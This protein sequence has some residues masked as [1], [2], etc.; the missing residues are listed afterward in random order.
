MQKEIGKIKKTLKREFYHIPIWL[1][2]LLAFS[3]LIRVYNLGDRSFWEDE[4]LYAISAEQIID[5][6]FRI[7]TFPGS[8]DLIVVPSLLYYYLL[9]GFQLL[10]GASEFAFRLPS[11]V[12]ATL[13]IFLVYKIGKILFADKT[14]FFATLL[15]S[16]GT[17]FLIVSREA[18]PI[19]FGMFFAILFIFF[20]LKI[21]NSKLKYYI[22]SVVSGVMAFVSHFMN[23]ALLLILP[24]MI[25]VRS[26]KNQIKKNLKFM[27]PLYLVLFVV[28][29]SIFLGM[30]L[31]L[32]HPLFSNPAYE[33]YQETNFTTIL[34]NPQPVLATINNGVDILLSSSAG[35]FAEALNELFSFYFSPSY[36][37]LPLVFFLIFFV[38]LVFRKDKGDLFVAI[39]LVSIVAFLLP[40]FAVYSYLD[41]KI[42]RS[43][44]FFIPPIFLV[45]G[46][47]ISILE[48]KRLLGILLL[49]I[50]LIV[51]LVR[52]PAILEK[53]LIS[54]YI[55]PRE[56]IIQ[57]N[58]R[59][60][61][62][63]NYM[64]LSFRDGFTFK[65][66]PEGLR[67]FKFDVIFYP[68]GLQGVVKTVKTDSIVCN[69]QE[70]PADSLQ[71]FLN[72]RVFCL[73]RH[74]VGYDDSAEWD[75]VT[76][77]I[78]SE[79]QPDDKW[80]ISFVSPYVYYSGNS[81]AAEIMDLHCN[82]KHVYCNVTRDLIEH[83]G[84]VWI[85]SDKERIHWQLNEFEKQHIQ[86]EC[87]FNEMASMFVYKC[88]NEQ[89]N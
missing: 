84:R 6:P 48:N 54:I 32:Q 43:H 22:L 69:P 34:E 88:L 74:P 37:Y 20:Y 68:E 5:N 11:V 15:M 30:V 87:K 8:K 79:N 56:N 10:L 52:L 72:G 46:R 19:T 38:N 61:P 3:F 35:G 12:F 7:P 55:P 27:L 41:L 24:L 66:F 44:F 39:W 75:S 80:Y 81:T 64:D 49:S 17:E 40:I 28:F 77:L 36:F 78:L 71:G 23:F 26:K 13:T 62:P 16:V 21:S 76:Q 70:Y 59:I 89:K 63:T 82:L 86:K 47:I 1:L 42:F 31:N 58:L 57:Y 9:A 85:V 65:V 67:E 45:F 33:L 51:Y 50:L 25:L 18:I 2:I 14:A 4:A 60:P 29:V 83:I 53:N 73:D